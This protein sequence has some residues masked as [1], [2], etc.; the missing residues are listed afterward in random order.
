MKSL[1]FEDAGQSPADPEVI[2]AFLQGG[3]VEALIGVARRI[4]SRLVSKEIIDIDE[5]NPGG[6]LQEC[7]PAGEG[8]SKVDE[9]SGG[10]AAPIPSKPAA[11]NLRSLKSCCSKCTCGADV[12]AAARSSGSR[13]MPVTVSPRAASCAERSPGP[14]PRSRMCWPRVMGHRARARGQSRQGNWRRYSWTSDIPC[15]LLQATA[16]LVG[17]LPTA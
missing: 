6:G 14:Q 12:R 7:A 4:R 8:R 13:S 3:A 10:E 16:C 5:T 11:G 9:V 15:V 17:R 2:A 1:R